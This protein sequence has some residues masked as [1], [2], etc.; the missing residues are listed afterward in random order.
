MLQLSVAYIVQ[1]RRSR[2]A[3]VRL[4]RARRWRFA[5]L[6][7]GDDIMAVHAEN[8]KRAGFITDTTEH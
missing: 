3:L 2:G 1:N 8:G 7:A 4:W 5:Y 6:Q